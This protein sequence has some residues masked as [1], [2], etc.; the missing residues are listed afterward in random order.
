MTC[1][2]RSGTKYL[3]INATLPLSAKSE[4]EICSIFAKVL[5]TH[6]NSD[7]ICTHCGFSF[8]AMLT[9]FIERFLR[10]SADSVSR[11]WQNKIETH[12]NEKYVRKD[13]LL[14]MIGTRMI[15]HSY[16]SPFHINDQEAETFEKVFGIDGFSD[17]HRSFTAK[18]K[19]HKINGN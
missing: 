12:H 4:V 5:E 2:C 13:C 3:Y 10:D 1:Q 14:D 15:G 6:P 16:S 7:K 11:Y 8:V 17:T 9:N 19:M 18:I